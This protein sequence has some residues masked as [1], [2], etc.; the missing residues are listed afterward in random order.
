MT[1]KQP[2]KKPQH[3]RSNISEGLRSGDLRDM[4]S[5][6]FSIDQFKSKMGEDRD[7]VVV[8]F[9]AKEKMPAV[10][11]M[12]FIEKGYQFVLDAD[13]STGEE[14]DGQYRVFVELER[15]SDVSRQIIEMLSGISKLTD[16]ESW[17]FNYFKDSNLYEANVDALS[18]HIPTTK[19]EYISKVE[20]AKQLKIQEFFNQGS[21]DVD[22]SEENQLIFHRPYSGD[23]SAQLLA[24]GDYETLKDQIPGKI[25]LDEGSIS[26]VTFLEKFLGNYEIHK[27]DNKFLIRNG[28]QAV[29]IKKEIW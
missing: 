14:R 10:D 7:V 3:Q 13:M 1:Y 2:H 16:C 9:K 23:V 26:Q 8:A 28:N 4:I 20:S 24:V 11:L 12:E 25:S 18:Q 17:D 21:V 19:E 29:I 6:I 27:I 15:T 5:P 22:L